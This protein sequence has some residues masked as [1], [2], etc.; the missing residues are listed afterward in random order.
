MTYSS[1]V[2][3][4]FDGAECARFFSLISSGEER[5]NLVFRA[6]QEAICFIANTPFLI[7]STTEALLHD[8]AGNG[9]R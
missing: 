2:M 1:E 7:S 5:S 4:R 9:A 8:A 3:C 6:V